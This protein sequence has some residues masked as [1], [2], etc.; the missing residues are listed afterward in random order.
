MVSC[1]KGKKLVQKKTSLYPQFLSKKRTFLRFPL[2]FKNCSETPPRDP[3]GTVFYVKLS[4][5]RVVL[6]SI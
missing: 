2:C 3:L 6:F 1:Q 5:E 4:K